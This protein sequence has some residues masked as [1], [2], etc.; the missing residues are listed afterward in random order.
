MLFKNMSQNVICRQNLTFY[1]SIAND[2]I[3]NVVFT[4]DSEIILET[5]TIVMIKKSNFIKKN[6]DATYLPI[7]TIKNA[8]ITITYSKEKECDKIIKG[9]IIYDN[10]EYEI[11]HYCI[12]ASRQIGKWGYDNI[13]ICFL[14][15]N[16]FGMNC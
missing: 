3:D 11:R 4:C 13:G 16:L 6:S 8:V 15:S 14:N 7:D 12:F 10:T 5:D 9:N 1:D 2:Y